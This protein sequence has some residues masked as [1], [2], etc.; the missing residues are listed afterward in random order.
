MTN[1]TTRHRSDDRPGAPEGTMRDVS[2]TNPYTRESFG[3]T[4][5]YRRGTV[6]DATGD[7]ENETRTDGGRRTE[8]T[9]P[10]G[11]VAQRVFDRGGNEPT[12]RNREA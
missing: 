1:D 4:G 8:H 9:G 2:H 12:V 6:S 3:E 5:T 7:R 11:V 10:G